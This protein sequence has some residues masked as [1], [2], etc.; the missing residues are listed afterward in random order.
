MFFSILPALRDDPIDGI[1]SFIDLIRD[2]NLLIFLYF[3][4]VNEAELTS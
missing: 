1:V 2:W 4:N 3:A